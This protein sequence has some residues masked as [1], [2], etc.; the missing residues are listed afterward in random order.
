MLTV[1][2]NRNNVYQNVKNKLTA[3][4]CILGN[5]KGTTEIMMTSAQYN[6]ET[7]V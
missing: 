4:H 3:L 2:Y 7:S 6:A 1:K 5:F